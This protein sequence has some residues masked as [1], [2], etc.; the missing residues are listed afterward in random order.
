MGR[1]DVG[2]IHK[3]IYCGEPFIIEKALQSL[4][5][6]KKVECKKK[7]HCM[8]Q[9]KC[10]KNKK[11]EEVRTEEANDVKAVEERMKMTTIIGAEV[12]QIKKEQEVVSIEDIDEIQN[13]AKELGNIRFRLIELIQKNEEEIKKYNEQDNIF[14]HRLELLE[15]LSDEDILAMCKGEKARRQSRRHI[16]DRYYLLKGLLDGIIIKNPSAFVKQVITGGEDVCTN[17]ENLKS[18]DGLWKNM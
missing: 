11:E 17:I 12:P 18:N 4:E 7:H 13:L 5:V 6:C 8:A 1:I 15:D 14:L 2:T 3:C 9:K 10:Y 16:K